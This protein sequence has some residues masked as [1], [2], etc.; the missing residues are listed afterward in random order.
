MDDIETLHKWIFESPDNGKT[1]LRRLSSRYD[2]GD[3]EINV[4]DDGSWITLNELRMIGKEYA[5]E[6]AM[7]KQHP[8]L[9]ELWKSYKTMVALLREEPDVRG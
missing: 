6:L 2:E 5:Q 8:Q 3:R 4:N 9:M 1:V 7:R